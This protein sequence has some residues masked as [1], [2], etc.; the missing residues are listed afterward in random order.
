MLWG[1]WKINFAGLN[2]YKFEAC[3]SEEHS[4]IDKRITDEVAKLEVRIVQSE[5]RILRWLVVLWLTQ[6]AAI[7]GAL[8]KIT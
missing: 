5:V 3:L 2:D 7:L 4:K 6:M 8:L 1:M